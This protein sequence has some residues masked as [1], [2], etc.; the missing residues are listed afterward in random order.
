MFPVHFLHNETTIFL[1]CKRM[2]KQQSS[3]S[4]VDSADDEFA[5]VLQKEFMEDARKQ[6]VREIKTL[7]EPAIVVATDQQRTDLLRFCTYEAS[8]ELQPLIPPFFPMVILR[9]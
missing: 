2:C 9:L 5:A 1:Q 4:Q 6:F 3:I 7:C 8:L